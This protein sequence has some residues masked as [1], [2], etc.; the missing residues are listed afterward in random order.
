METIR[1]GEIAQ[2]RAGIPA[3]KQIDDGEEVIYYQMYN[4]NADTNKFE[5][6]TIATIKKKQTEKHLLY[7]N[8]VLLTAKGAR[9]YCALYHPKQEEKAIA[10]G[11][12]FVLKVIDDRITP[13]Y[14]SWFLNRPEI[15]EKIKRCSSG[16]FAVEKKE[17]ISLG[18]PLISI[19]EQHLIYESFTLL[20]EKR[21]IQIE[22][23]E[24]WQLHLFLGLYK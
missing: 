22:L 8:D 12:F 7:E 21:R 2:I 24:T 4:Y 20:I 18:I 10:C 13:Q 19:E 3:Y 17:V 15:G 9:Y 23:I 5:N 1:I 11:A 6:G 16:Y 14:L